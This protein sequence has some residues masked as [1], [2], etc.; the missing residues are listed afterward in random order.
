MSQYSSTKERLLDDPHVGGDVAADP[1]AR[2]APAEPAAVAAEVVERHAHLP[3]V[4]DVE[5]EVVQAGS[6]PARG[7]RRR[8]RGGPRRRAARRRP[9][10]GGRSAAKPEHVD[11][12]RRA[13][14]PRRPVRKFTWPSRRGWPRGAPEGAR[15]KEVR[16]VGPV[17][18]GMS[19][20][21]CP[22]GRSHQ[23]AS[24]SRQATTPAPSS[25]AAASSRRTPARRRQA[26]VV[27]ARAPARRRRSARS[28]TARRHR[29][30]SPGRPHGPLVQA[31]LRAPAGARLV[32]VA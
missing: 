9:P 25:R 26:D 17:R 2:R 13:A 21:R 27:D 10:P 1:V 5:R 24:P 22:R 8:A 20:T 3:D 31:E 19:L 23:T 15:A 28:R 4:D 16:A 30:G 29:P 7:R 18:A 14:P 12:R 6:W 11:V 32:E